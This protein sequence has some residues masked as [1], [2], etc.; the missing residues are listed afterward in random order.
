MICFRTITLKI[1]ID[2][3]TIDMV[4]LLYFFLILTTFKGLLPLNYMCRKKTVKGIKMMNLIIPA[5]LKSLLYIGSIIGTIFI[6]DIIVFVFICLN[7]IILEAISMQINKCQKFNI[8]PIIAEIF[9]IVAYF[10]NL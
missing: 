3:K 1:I 9:I 7:T 6:R 4:Q 8:I 10:C 5:F 2:E